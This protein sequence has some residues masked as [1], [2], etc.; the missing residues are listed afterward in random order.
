MIEIIMTMRI[1]L[2][3]LSYGLKFGLSF[4]AEEQK[5]MISESKVLGLIVAPKKHEDTED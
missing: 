5:L 3:V 1:T 2:S 4:H